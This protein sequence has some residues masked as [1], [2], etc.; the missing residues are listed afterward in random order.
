MTNYTNINLPVIPFA[1]DAQGNPIY[2]GSI[3][4]SLCSGGMGVVCYIV[5]EPCF[6]ILWNDGCR[7]WLNSSYG[8]GFLKVIAHVWAEGKEDFINYYGKPKG[9]I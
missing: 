5:K 8:Y 3:V 9:L 7:A 6:Y 2:A 1:K 4:E